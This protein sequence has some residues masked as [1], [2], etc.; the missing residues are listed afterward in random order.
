MRERGGRTNGV[1]EKS[2][3]EFTV[4]REGREERGQAEALIMVLWKRSVPIH[5]LGSCV[6]NLHT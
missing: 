5:G 4:E 3:I 2:Q 6:K 1:G